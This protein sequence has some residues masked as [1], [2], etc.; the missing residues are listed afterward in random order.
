VQV[1]C[2]LSM[3]SQDAHRELMFLM[4]HALR[5]SPCQEA[6]KKLEKE[7]NTLGIF[8]TVTDWNGATRTRTFEDARRLHPQV[9]PSHLKRLALTGAE[10]WRERGPDYQSLPCTLLRKPMNGPHGEGPRGDSFISAA[11]V[12]H[13]RVP[14]RGVVN[15]VFS[16]RARESGLG[17]NRK[18][19]PRIYQRIEHQASIMGHFCAVYCLVFDRTGLRY[20]TGSDDKLIKIWVSRN[21]ILLR[22][23]RGHIS[24]IVDLAVSCDNRFLASCSNDQDVRIWWLHN[25]VPLAV[26]PGHLGVIN[27]VCWSATLSMD[28]SQQLY[29]WSDDGTL[30]TWN[31]DASGIYTGCHSLSAVDIAPSSRP[32]TAS[33][34]H[35]NA[36]TAISCACFDPTGRWVAIGCADT[37]I[38]I[39]WLNAPGILRPTKLSGHAGSVDSI[40]TNK[41]GNLIVSGS[42]DGSVRVWPISF[43]TMLVWT[44]GRRYLTMVTKVSGQSPSSP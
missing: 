38:R 39:Y 8:G 30:R 44:S 12:Q 29:S 17:R 18:W 32:S 41:H 42:A 37:L 4:I 43:V 5:A 20:I 6:A 23:L 1:A 25:G 16:L 34:A 28:L 7:A 35:T 2:A 9:V 10:L 27:N 19:R 24:D 31:I 15:E 11:V 40:F 21:G 22:T 14:L 3:S 36:P 26:L 13:R 33:A